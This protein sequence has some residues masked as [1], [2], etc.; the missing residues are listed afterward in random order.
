MSFTEILH[1]VPGSWEI[2]ST[3]IKVNWTCGLPGACQNM[4]AMCRLA[5]PSSPH[6]E[7]EEVEGEETLH[8][9][10]GT[11]SCSLLQP[12]TDYNVTITLPPST[13]LLAWLIRTEGT[14]MC[15]GVQ[16]RGVSP[17]WC[18]REGSWQLSSA[19]CPKQ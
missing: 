8:G 19:I 2:S 16:E 15:T 1:V 7:A 4:Q 13:I 18:H 12:F 14:G 11:F 6:C 10:E 3:S 9:Q 5:Q 17:V